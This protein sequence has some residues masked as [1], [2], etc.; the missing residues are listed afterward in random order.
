MSASATLKAALAANPDLTVEALAKMP[1]ERALQL[2]LVGRQVLAEA[3]RQA[4]LCGQCRV[5]APEEIRAARTAAGLTQTQAARLVCST[6]RT[7]QGWEAPV[8]SPGHR[9]MPS[10]L[11]V[12]FRASVA[13]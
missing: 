12:L 11:W 2:Y 5:P 1:D 8:G 3:G 7:W 9:K 4:G 13:S 6:L 10:G